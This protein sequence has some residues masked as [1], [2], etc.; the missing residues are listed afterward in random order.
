MKFQI[1]LLPILFFLSISNSQA[2]KIDQAQESLLFEK[3]SKI[4]LMIEMFYKQPIDNATLSQKT[5]KLVY[6][7][8]LEGLTI[9]ELE[10]VKNWKNRKLI[11]IP[12]W[13]LED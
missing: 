2:G 9:E 13:L 6:Q 12:K 5:V 4:G 10:L 8:F 11:A 3:Y 1:I 7:H